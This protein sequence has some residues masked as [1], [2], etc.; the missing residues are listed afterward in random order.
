MVT[1]RCSFI[2]SFNPH[3]TFVIKEETLFFFSFYFPNCTTMTQRLVSGLGLHLD[4]AV[5][6]HNANN[7]LSFKSEAKVFVLLY[8]AIMTGKMC[9]KHSVA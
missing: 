5:S 1:K 2:L 6:H 7:V 8:L 3:N 4:L 9:H